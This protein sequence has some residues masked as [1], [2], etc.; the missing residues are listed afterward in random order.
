MDEKYRLAISVGAISGIATTI[1]T[2]VY[3]LA[4]FTLSN[5]LMA[6]AG[7]PICARYG[8]GLFL[9]VT[10]KRAIASWPIGYN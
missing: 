6:L 10:G 3:L 1:P 9:Y 7:R 4:F 8:R 2:V 5:I